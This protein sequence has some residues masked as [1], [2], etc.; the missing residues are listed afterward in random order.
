MKMDL[1]QKLPTLNTNTPPPQV[2]IEESKNYKEDLTQALKELLQNYK[3]QPSIQ[4]NNN[5][6]PKPVYYVPT[7]SSSGNIGGGRG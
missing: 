2:K 5:S 4:V 6:T 3:I 7:N 1:N